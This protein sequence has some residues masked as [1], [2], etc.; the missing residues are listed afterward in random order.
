MRRQ[1]RTSQQSAVAVALVFLLGSVGLGETAW[2]A[3]Q[4][5]T[6]FELDE[7][8]FSSTG[9]NAHFS[10]RSGDRLVLE[11]MDDRELVRVQI[12]VLN[13]TKKITFADAEGESLTVDARVVEEREWKDGALV[14]V[15]RNFYARCAQT[16]DI[17]Y[18]G[19][20]VDIYEDG[21]IVS[22]DGA[23]LAGKNGALPGLIMPGRFLLG[24]RYF[25]EIAPGVALDRA[26]HVKMG[27]TVTT[28]AGTFEDCVEVLE[29]T[30]LEPGATSVKRYCAEI[31][32][33][34]D[35]AVTLVDYEIAGADD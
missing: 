3:P 9:R 25:Q 4:Y 23:W 10:I 29:T 13:Q 34:M 17:F 32:L 1:R 26:E 28:P 27:L 12:T 21:V 33:V 24:S 30:P 31:G 22:H 7:C 5:T 19:E 16:G 11:G 18:L 2:A 8:T 14:E 20:D 6:Q 15:S 35:D